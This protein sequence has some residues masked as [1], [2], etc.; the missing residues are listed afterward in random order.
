MSLPSRPT[1]PGS[2]GCGRCGKRYAF[3]EFSALPTQRVLARA[4]LATV[5]TEWP[6]SVTVEVRVCAHCA[7]P[8]ARLSRPRS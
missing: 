4:D 2:V 3:S 8:I 7:S 1:H 6:E 5:V